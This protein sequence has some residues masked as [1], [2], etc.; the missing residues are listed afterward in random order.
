MS[1]D[2][3]TKLGGLRETGILSE[4]R[5][6]DLFRILS[7]NKH[8]PAADLIRSTLGE[9]GNFPTHRAEFA[10]GEI[11][12]IG[13]ALPGRDGEVVFRILFQILSSAEPP[14][15]QACRGRMLGVVG[16][17]VT[18]TL[19]RLVARRVL[20]I[21]HNGYYSISDVVPPS[22]TKLVIKWPNGT[23][24]S[25]LSSLVNQ[26]AT[27]NGHGLTSHQ[28][29]GLRTYSVQISVLEISWRSQNMVR[30]FS[31]T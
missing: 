28:Q 15:A 9:L 18:S 30:C 27:G 22:F 4:R 11:E 8:H 6:D 19:S 31:K 21:D 23:L 10:D 29:T 17:R 25:I 3:R 16:G 13:R 26:T 2:N 24:N 12:S 20:S 14:H 7:L 5:I 1:V